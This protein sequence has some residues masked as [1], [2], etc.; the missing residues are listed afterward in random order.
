MG[1]YTYQTAAAGMLGIKIN[2]Q[3]I[4]TVA[5]GDQGGIGKWVYNEASW[6]ASTG[7]QLLTFEFFTGQGSVQRIDSI[8]ITA[9]S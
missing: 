6:T 5:P 2:G 9:T 7:Q 1:F 4:R 8:T 3:A